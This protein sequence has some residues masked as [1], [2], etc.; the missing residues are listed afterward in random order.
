MANKTQE[1]IEKAKKAYGVAEEA[2][3]TFLGR[4]ARSKWTFAIVLGVICAVAVW[5]LT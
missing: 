5:W 3:D 4:L 2:T 1:R